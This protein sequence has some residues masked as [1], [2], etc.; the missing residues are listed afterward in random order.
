MKIYV[1]LYKQPDKYFE[2][3]STALSAFKTEEKAQDYLNEVK[4]VHFQSFVEEKMFLEEMTREEATK[5]AE[6]YFKQYM[7]YYVNEVELVD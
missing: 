3:V 4:D 7:D 5:E 1:A 2:G 6:W